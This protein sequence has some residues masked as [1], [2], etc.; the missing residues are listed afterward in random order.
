MSPI[1]ARA[2]TRCALGDAGFSIIE[3]VVAIALLALIFV[4]ISYIL[5]STQSAA[6]DYHLR[7][8]AV[9][10]GTQALET[11]EYQ[12]ASNVSPTPGTTTT[13]EYSGSDPFTVAVE[14][15]LVTGGGAASSLCTAATGTTAS[16]IWLV[17]ATVS[18]GHGPEK[19]RVV[20]STII[21]PTYTDL[22]DV[23]SAELAIPVYNADDATLET[24]TEIH[25][26][27]S[28]S[29]AAGR[30]GTLPS[31][32]Y[33][34]EQGNTGS[35]GCAVFANLYA[36]DGVTYTVTA[37]GNS[38]FVDPN[39]LSDATTA[40]GVPT[41]T[42]VSV[43][44][45]TVSVLSDPFIL[46]EGATTTVTFAT[47][48]STD[49][50]AADIPISVQSS[51]L[52]CTALS[53]DTCVLGNGSTSFTSSPPETAL[54][55]PGPAVTPNYSMWAGD[56]IDSE[57]NEYG[58]VATSLTATSGALVSVTVPVYPLNLTVT[59]NADAGTG[60]VLTATDSGGGDTI[61]LNSV[62]SGASDT[63]L[64][65]GQYLLQATNNTDT[66]ETVSSGG[67]TPAYVW[68]LPTGVCESNVV[69][70]T[71]C[72]S[73]KTSIAVTIG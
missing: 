19:G 18:W 20:Q 6:N 63:G 54:L 56:Q 14:Y 9:D 52:L 16:R 66:S 60:I 2:T 4:P 65:L 28:G 73:P 64:P 70:S 25:I 23:D 55:F 33:L 36:G 32:E 30:C 62:T 22:A 50:P 40:P 13:T 17:T 41:R 51:T 42:G 15:S 8:E 27:V 53:V 34:N 47:Q 57:P 11:A 46:A 21:S 69:A 1:V 67:K 59:E 37:V 58:L 48:G 49:S 7:A 44:A 12:T 26:D 5:I 39:E 10:L 24:T 35:T 3:V 68:V 29:C 72:A 61:T 38:G 43:Q 71:P 31:N 45:N